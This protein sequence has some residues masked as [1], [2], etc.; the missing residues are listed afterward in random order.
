MA[1]PEFSN[2]TH[3]L[4]VLPNPIEDKWGFIVVFMVMNGKPKYNGIDYRSLKISRYT[5]ARIVSLS[6]SSKFMFFT[7]LALSA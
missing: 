4:D 2:S 5:L 6:A 3:H 7:A 1:Q